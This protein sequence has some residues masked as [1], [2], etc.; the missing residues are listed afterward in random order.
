MVTL[1]LILRINQLTEKLN[2]RS[3][4]NKDLNL[5]VNRKKITS[6]FLME[7]R[8]CPKCNKKEAISD[9]E[10]GEVVCGSCG[11][12]IS[13]R[14]EESGP[15]WRSFFGGKPNRIRTGSGTSL[16]IHDMGLATI[17]GPLNKDA[18]GKPLSLDMTSMIRRIRKWDNQSRHGEGI[19]RNLQQA[20]TYLNTMKDKL[21]IPNAV[22][23]KAA[24]LYRKALEKNLLSGKTISTFMAAALYAACRETETPRTR[25]EIAK[26][27]NIPNILLGVCYRRLVKELD[28]KMP[29]VDP[30]CCIARISSKIGISEKIK[31]YAIEILRKAKENNISAGKDP[32]GLA[33]SAL[34]L[35]CVKMNENHSQ[36]KLAEAAN[37][38]TITIRNRCKGL[39][40]IEN[41]ADLG[42]I[43]S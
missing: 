4:L 8:W 23:E 32:M 7:T 26:A 34:Y 15:E 1:N 38:T 39:R 36:A 24:Y 40:N 29:V 33:A 20:F 10:V 27:A 37:L 28:L 3:N 9:V 18:I 5:G 35:S 14:I 17:I 2:N 16:A 6:Y 21:A 19:D 42:I 41:L 43:K 13:D 12:V 11:L 22:I 25:K 31:R 30:V